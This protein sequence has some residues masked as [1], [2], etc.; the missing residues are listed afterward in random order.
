MSTRINQL[1]R[2]GIGHH[3]ACRLPKRCLQRGAEHPPTS[4]GVPLEGLVL[5]DRGAMIET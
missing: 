2:A 4:I 1:D 5:A 3:K